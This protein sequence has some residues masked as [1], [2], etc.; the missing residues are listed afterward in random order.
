MQDFILNEQRTT[1]DEQRTDGIAKMLEAKLI[2]APMAGVTDGPFR[3]MARRFGCRFAYTEMI[4]SNAFIYHSKRTM[5]M[6]THPA[7]DTPLGAQIAGE[8]A[9]RMLLLAQACEEIG[10]DVIDVNAGCPSKKVVKGGKGAALMKDPA[11]LAGIVKKLVNGVKLPVTVKMRSGWD[12]ENMNYLEV[13]KAV[14]AEGARAICVHP[15]TREQMYKGKAAHDIVKEVKDA[16]KI[17]VFASGNIFSP[18]DVA[19]VLARTGCDGVYVA[20]GALGRP[21]IFRETYDSFEGKTGFVE[22]SFEDIRALMAE[23]MQL[24]LDVH[25]EKRAYSRMYKNICWY[26]KKYKNLHPI[27]ME[28]IKAKT[29]EAFAVFLSRLGLDEGKYLVLK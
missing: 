13:A 7:E 4:D 3:L 14:E 29:P 19:D 8:D 26:L 11:K 17:P 16:V 28:Y 22:P 20:R 24:C 15:R 18:E 1:S 27:M 2:L 12:D 6:L 21:W 10:F 9:Q 5:R 23:H 25:G